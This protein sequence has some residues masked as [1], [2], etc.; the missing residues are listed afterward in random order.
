MADA[1]KHAR[2][3]APAVAPE[4]S[5]LETG[6]DGLWGS[7]ET[8]SLARDGKVPRAPPVTV[9][10]EVWNKRVTD[11][12]VVAAYK[13]TGS[14]WKAAKR[15]G[16]VG[17]S[18][19]ERLRRL[20]YPMAHQEWTEEERREARSLAEQGEPIGHIAARLGRTYWA[21]ALK[22]SRLGVSSQRSDWRK[23]P[24][25]GAG[26]T[27][28]RV[29]AFA[30]KLAEGKMTVR[31]LA[32][33]EG[34]AITPLVDALQYYEPERWQRYVMDHSDLGIEKCPGCGRDFVPL[35]K[36]QQFCTGRC[37][38][39]HRRNLAYFGGRRFDAIGLRE[40]V[41]Q[42][43]RKKVEKWLSAHHV[44]GKE[45]DPENEALIA[46]CRG[47]HDVVTRL[48]SRPWMEDP[49][50]VADLIALALAR[51]GRLT[52]FVSVELED[53]T[54]EEVQDYVDSLNETG[55]EAVAGHV[56][57]P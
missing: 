47:C 43:C 42:L 30:R 27:K 33:M 9:R 2:V 32:R 54:A 36:K 46:L 1:R 25:H 6:D 39:A 53:W 31:R 8:R 55:E 4:F 38:E 26:L 14:I 35:T 51:R 28:K 45:K 18:V 37:R 7:S 15:L 10:R 50:V 12:E 20:G 21:V 52:A 48:A 3:S 40:G 11:E 5:A 17:Q 19:H 23:K 34:V 56:K 29:V 49:E 13:E 44:L 22:L 16:L 24:K 57:N 41:C